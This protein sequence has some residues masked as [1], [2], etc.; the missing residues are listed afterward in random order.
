MNSYVPTRMLMLP[1]WIPFVLAGALTVF[2][3]RSRVSKGC[4]RQCGYN[5]TGN[6]SGR[7]PEC[8]SDVR[9]ARF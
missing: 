6:V 2:C 5:L 9:S 1:L 3:W 7:C 4:C 8:G